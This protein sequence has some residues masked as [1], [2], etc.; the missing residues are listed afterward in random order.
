MFAWRATRA[1]ISNAMVVRAAGRAGRFD[2]RFAG[3][4]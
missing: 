1:L 3:I 4:S 2:I